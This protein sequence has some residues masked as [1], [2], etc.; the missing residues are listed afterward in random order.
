M[1]GGDALRREMRRAEILVRLDQPDASQQR[2]PA[3]TAAIF[4]RC[5]GWRRAAVLTM[6]FMRAFKA[7]DPSTLP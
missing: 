6:A 7:C 2:G 5:R 4:G 1:R 3:A